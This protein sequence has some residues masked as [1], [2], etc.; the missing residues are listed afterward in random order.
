MNE[1][2][3]KRKSVRKYDM[4]ELSSDVIENVQEAIRNVK[5]LYPDIK[6]SIDIVK[7]TKGMF[8]IKAPHYLVFRSEKVEKTYENIGFIGQQLDLYFSEAGLGCCWLGLSK[9]EEIGQSELSV[10][11]C[12]SFGKPN[13]TLHRDLTDFKRK[14]LSEI[15]E[16]ADDRLEAA[17]LA[18]SGLNAQNWYFI[19]D[20][21]CIHC[22]VK[23]PKPM[24]KRVM[25]K[26]G[27]IDLGIAICHI[28]EESNNFEFDVIENAPNRKGY[29][30]IGTVK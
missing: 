1:F 22:Y 15:S 3:R 30:Y 6:F 5:P 14:P 24:L 10:I 23:N 4:T 26:L 13:E 17:R 9:P 28:F 19:A 12:M 11:I 16:G 29:E 27:R 20:N 21:G 18:P 2:I 25:T 8:G 7:K